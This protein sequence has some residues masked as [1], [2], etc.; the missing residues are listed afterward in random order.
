VYLLRDSDVH[1]DVELQAAIAA[2]AVAEKVV[3]HQ[4]PSALSRAGDR[5][6][7]N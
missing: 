3:G 4:L 7:G 5:I 1:V 2:A 6:L